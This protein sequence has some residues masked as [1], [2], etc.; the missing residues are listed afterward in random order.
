MRNLLIRLFDG[1]GHGA[2]AALAHTLVAEDPEILDRL[3]MDALLTEIDAQVRAL[4]LPFFMAFRLG[5]FSF[6]YLPFP[7]ARKLRPFSRLPL[8]KRIDYVRRWEYARF[9]MSRN[10]FKLLKIL[11]L[12]AMMRQEPL[13]RHIG[14]GPSIDHRR[15]RPDLPP[16]KRVC[17]R[18]GEVT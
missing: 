9:A 14:Y 2:M 8:A 16:E 10:L 3:D 18:V 11:T 5:L 4:P 6:E 12:A 17:P 13:Y 7:F 1:R 15:Q